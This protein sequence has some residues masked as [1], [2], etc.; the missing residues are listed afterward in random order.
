MVYDDDM[1]GDNEILE[2]EVCAPGNSLEP[3]RSDNKPTTDPDVAQEASPA[4]PQPKAM[5]SA[6]S[7]G[8]DEDPEQPQDNRMRTRT[9]RGQLSDEDPY[10][11]FGTPVESWGS[12]RGARGGTPAGTGLSDDDPYWTFGTPPS[13]WGRSRQQQTQVDRGSVR[14]RVYLECQRCGVKVEKKREHQGRVPCPF[15]NRPMR[16]VGAAPDIMD[17]GRHGQGGNTRQNRDPR[18]AREPGPDDGNGNQ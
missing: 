7:E 13:S 4:Q 15:C 6:P 3:L 9:A 12:T 16:L 1:I 11:Q 2:D 14:P 10:W 17:M 5:A 18:P 8:S